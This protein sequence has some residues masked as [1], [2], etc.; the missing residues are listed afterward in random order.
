MKKI[1]FKFDFKTRHAGISTLLTIA[2]LAGIIIINILIGELPAQADLTSKK[3]YSLTD[4]TREYIENLDKDVEI[5]ALYGTGEEPEGIMQTLGEYER[6][7]KNIRLRVV[8]P[9]R[10]PGTIAKYSE[11]EQPL[12][13]GSIIVSSGSNFRVI[14]AM[15]LYDVSYSQQGQPQVMGQK[16]EQQITTAVA[17]VTSGNVP[18]I[19]EITG[20]QETTLASMG[21]G[22]MLSQANFELGEISLIL[23]DIPEDAAL[24][25]LV[26]PR[27]DI[28]AAEAEKIKAYL[29][30]GGS[31]FVAMDLSREP[32]TNINKLLGEWDIEVLQGLVL[33]TEKNRLIAEFGDNPFVFA[34]YRADHEILAP[35]V[36]SKLDP[37]LQA[38]LGFKRTD[39]RQRQL[40][41]ASLLTSSEASRLRTDL[42]SEESG[43]ASPLPGDTKGPIDV[44]VALNQRT[45]DSYKREGASIVVLGSASSLGGLG[46][47]GKIKANADLLLNMLNWALDDQ[48]TISVP[49]KSLFRLPLCIDTLSAFAYAGI[50]IILI[51]LLCLGG[52]LFVFFRRRHK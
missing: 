24:L 7:S 10:N 15:D 1:N 30:G 5:L 42:T 41:Y 40:E 27:A 12:S 29:N 28:S 16:V 22:G 47:L 45:M 2:V 43:T 3:L 9:D 8:D 31:L 33:E 26:G 32:F 6:L 25:T 13:A 49:G 4:Q 14:A 17:Y 34:P 46:Y 51:P 37:V 36:E 23:S 50:S 20:H 18:R 19:L 38:S 35:L 39:A 44:A 52:A 48:A 11:G 21:Y